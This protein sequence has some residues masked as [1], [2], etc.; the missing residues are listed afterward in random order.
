MIES[1]TTNCPICGEEADAIYCRKNAVFTVNPA[2][3][4]NEAGWYMEEHEDP[5]GEECCYWYEGHV[6][7]PATLEDCVARLEALERMLAE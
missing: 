5:S 6:P 2:L 3:P 7:G 1:Y 4:K